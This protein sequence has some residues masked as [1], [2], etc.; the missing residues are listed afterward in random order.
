MNKFCNN[1]GEKLDVNAKICTN[2]A[3]VFKDTNNSTSTDIF[4]R[5]KIKNKKSIVAIMIIVLLASILIVTIPK[6]FLTGPEQTAK[7]FFNSIANSDVDKFISTLSQST[8]VENDFSFVDLQD[9]TLKSEYQKDLMELNLDMQDELGVDYL[10]K[11]TY[12]V[13]KNGN[14]AIISVSYEKMPGFLLISMIKE[15]RDWKIIDID[16]TY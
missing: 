5:S 15:G 8:L 4:T 10:K 3:Y 1:C 7:T 14:S 9:P 12:N 11:L 2:C 6:L 13:N 16:D